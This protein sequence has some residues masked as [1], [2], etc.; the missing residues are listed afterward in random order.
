MTIQWGFKKQNWKYLN[1]QNW[2]FAF[3]VDYLKDTDIN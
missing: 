2:N 1:F 3:L